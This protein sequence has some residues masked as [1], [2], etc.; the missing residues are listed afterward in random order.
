MEFKR[1]ERSVV[2]RGY[3]AGEEGSLNENPGK[4]R[5]KRGGKSSGRGKRI[6]HR[7][8]WKNMG[9][10]GRKGISEEET[11][12]YDEKSKA[13]NFQHHQGGA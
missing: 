4:E 8:G 10:T 3:R 7:E 6:S 2:M 5:K 9:R 13:G 12:L 1:E 11:P